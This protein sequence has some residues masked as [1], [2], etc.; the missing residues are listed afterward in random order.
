VKHEAVV[1]VKAERHHRKHEA[2]P[3]IAEK[4]KVA[5]LPKA[6]APV[7]SVAEPLT[8]AAPVS[9]VSVV[10]QTTEHP[11]LESTAEVAS[12]RRLCRNSMILEDV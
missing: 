9:V 8:V 11:A 10:R 12:T 3:E 1:P 7:V 4:K 6:E 5:E 2:K